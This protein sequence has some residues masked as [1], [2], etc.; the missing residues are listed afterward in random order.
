MTTVEVPILNYV[1][2]FRRLSWR[3][4]L[5]FKPGKDLFREKLIHALVSVSGLPVSSVEEA[6]KVLSPMAYP[7]IHRVYFLYWN[8]LPPDRG[9]ETGS[10]YIAPEPDEYNEQME[11]EISESDRI[12]DRAMRSLEGRFTK[13]QLEEEAE[14]SRKIVTNSKLRGATRPTVDYPEER[15]S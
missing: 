4:E 13:E 9:F 5:D 3:E 12:A 1:F 7:V 10:L 14:I 15:N 6:R 8:S 2:R 11:K